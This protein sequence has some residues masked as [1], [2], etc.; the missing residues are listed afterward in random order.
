M[1]DWPRRASVRMALAP[2]DLFGGA[3]RSD[4]EQPLIEE[5]LVMELARKVHRMGGQFV[6]WPRFKVSGGLDQFDMRTIDGEV[7]VIPQ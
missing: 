5:K 1:N 7:W 6:G 3:Y 4:E 2:R